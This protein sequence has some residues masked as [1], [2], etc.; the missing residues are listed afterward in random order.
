MPIS[1]RSSRT[2]VSSGV[3]PGSTLPPGNSH[4]PA[5]CLALRP[6]REQ[7]AAVGVD[8]RAG[9]DEQQLLSAGIAVVAH[10]APPGRR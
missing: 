7:H 6:L 3:S 8:Q 5:S 2:S 4:S 10:A 9:G 1:S